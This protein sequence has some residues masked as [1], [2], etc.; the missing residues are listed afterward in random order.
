MSRQ[1]KVTLAVIAAE[2]GV[3]VA[4]VSLALRGKSNISDETRERVLDAAR[5]L[6]YVRQ[7]D[8]PG[9]SPNGLANVGLVIKTLPDNPRDNPFYSIVQAG[10]ELACRAHRLNL[11]YASLPVDDDSR[12]V[13][14]PRLFSDGRLDGLLV[15]GMQLNDANA[16]VFD[17]FH[18]P[19]VLVDAY[20]E[21]QAYD[22]VV[23]ANIEGAHAAA[24]HLI[25]LG[26][27]RIALV[28]S[29]LNAFPSI[30]QRRQGYERAL[31]EHGL[32]PGPF[33]DCSLVGDAA[34]SATYEALQQ[35][36]SITAIVGVNDE[37]T[38]W[39]MRAAKTLGC[40]VPGDI[41]F[42]GFDD[43]LLAGHVE[44]ALTTMRVDKVGMGRL[45][46]ELLIQ[47]VAHPD[48]AVV[49]AVLQPTLVVRDSVA[50]TG[51]RAG[52]V[53]TPPLA[54]ERSDAHR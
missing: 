20:A 15:V 3:S 52:L 49:Q 17:G 53:P 12:I 19:I 22:S 37:V 7:T 44:P 42:V 1:P 25:G 41:S 33:I 40:G 50:A 38:I 6:G 8:V 13:D 43:D 29:H 11:L 26:H 4:A 14:V 54:G 30:A 48:A 36:R 16:A 23:S 28:G 39:A 32:G 2:T 24:S 45:G 9:R 31:V 34:F 46:V 27:E 18:A 51:K 47:R 21:S 35:D 10:V 5:R